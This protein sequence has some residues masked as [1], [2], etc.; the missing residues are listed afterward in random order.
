MPYATVV[1]EKGEYTV[2]AE[3]FGKGIKMWLLSQGESVEVI[4]C[5]KF[6]EEMIE[7][8]EKMRKVYI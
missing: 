8:I 1:E 7:T 4:G 6:R 3:L 2:E 5:D